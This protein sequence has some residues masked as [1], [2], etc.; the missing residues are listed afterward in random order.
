MDHNKHSW[1]SSYYHKRFTHSNPCPSL[2]IESYWVRRTWGTRRNVDTFGR[3]RWTQIIGNLI[4]K[5]GLIWIQLSTF[6]RLYFKICNPSLHLWSSLCHVIQPILS[7][8]QGWGHGHLWGP[9]CSLPQMLSGF[10]ELWQNHLDRQ[11]G[12]KAKRTSQ[13]V[14]VQGQDPR[15]WEALTRPPRSPWDRTSR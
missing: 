14:W 2:T 10:P 13:R 5:I 11:Q 12:I 15:L 3:G 4:S 8:V 9:L 1:N 7:E 6:K